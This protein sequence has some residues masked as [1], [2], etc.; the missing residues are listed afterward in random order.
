MTAKDYECNVTQLMGR[1]SQ[2]NMVQFLEKSMPMLRAEI[3]AGRVSVDYII[4]RQKGGTTDSPSPQSGHGA[5]A[6]PQSLPGPSPVQKPTPSP[7][8]P[9]NSD[10]M[11][12]AKLTESPLNPSPS[13]VHGVSLYIDFIYE[14]ND[15]FSDISTGATTD[16][17][18][19]GSQSI[20][21]T[22]NQSTHANRFSTSFHSPRL[23]N[24]L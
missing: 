17:G 6:S 5:T 13:S 19:D 14:F 15:G 12:R 23:R 9:P 1:Q 18:E 3:D 20:S 2:P 7:M 8:Q 22:F 21:T 4:G 16:I 10:P 24:C 11:M